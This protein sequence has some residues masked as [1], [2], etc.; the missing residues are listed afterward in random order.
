MNSCKKV[1]QQKLRAAMAALAGSNA[2]TVA[3]LLRS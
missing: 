3:N 1:A 2:T